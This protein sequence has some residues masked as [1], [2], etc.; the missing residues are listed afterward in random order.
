MPDAA[1][2]HR[3][4]ASVR[5]RVQV[6]APPPDVGDRNCV[7]RAMQSEEVQRPPKVVFRLGYPPVRG[8]SSLR[9]GDEVLSGEL[10]ERCLLGQ[11]VH[12][13]PLAPR[14]ELI[15][16][17]ESLGSEDL[18]DP[19][20]GRRQRLARNDERLAPPSHVGIVAEVC[21]R[22]LRA[23]YRYDGAGR[24]VAEVSSD[25]RRDSTLYDPA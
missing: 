5:L 8:R 15:Q 4:A 21:V 19:E 14:A 22:A 2:A 17:R 6:L 11:V 9:L 24:R 23:T 18:G 13:T 10:R 7:E 1:A 25:G 12:R 20:I 3:A 16:L